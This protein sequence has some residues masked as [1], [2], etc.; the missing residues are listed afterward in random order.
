MTAKTPSPL[1][2]LVTAFS[3]SLTT[4]SPLRSR[5]ADA[6]AKAADAAAKPDAKSAAPVTP[7]QETK[8][9]DPKKEQPKKEE[10]KKEE[11]K[12]P[13]PSPSSPQW[14]LEV[15]KEKPNIHTPSVVC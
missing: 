7:G 3:L 9:E 11:P 6:P 1:A 5:A 13:Y 12:L 2:R 8:K 14:K 10:P 4:S 15:L